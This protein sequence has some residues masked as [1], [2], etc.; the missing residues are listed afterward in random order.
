MHVALRVHVQTA[1]ILVQK[2]IEAHLPAIIQEVI[3]HTLYRIHRLNDAPAG[4]GITRACDGDI[5]ASGVE[6][7]PTS[8]GRTQL[9]HKS[10]VAPV[11]Q[12]S[13]PCPV[14]LAAAG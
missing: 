8:T 1:F 14:E 13:A 3:A 10:D 4:H 12:H 2:S 5:T 11:V 6:E 7:Y 9:S